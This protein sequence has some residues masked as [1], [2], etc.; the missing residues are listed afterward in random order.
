MSADGNL[1]QS[2]QRTAGGLGGSFSVK[3]S[4]LN[5]TGYCRTTRVVRVRGVKLK[6]RDHIRALGQ[7][8]VNHWSD[9]AQVL[10]VNQQSVR[11]VVTDDNRLPVWLVPL[12]GVHV[13]I[14][15]R[16]LIRCQP[17]RAQ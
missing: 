14:D 5:R 16:E 12:F 8:S 6:R 10:D 13:V 9:L 17:Q 4:F 11:H 7:R 2:S 15:G 1:E 3:A